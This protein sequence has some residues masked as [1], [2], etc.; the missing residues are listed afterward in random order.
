MVLESGRQFIH[1]PSHRSGGDSTLAWINEY[2]FS[3]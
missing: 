1:P 2:G 3:L